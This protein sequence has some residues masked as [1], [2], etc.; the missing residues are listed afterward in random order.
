MHVNH[1]I[2]WLKELSHIIRYQNV[3]D[4]VISQKGDYIISN[5]ASEYI[6]DN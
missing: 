6:H 2:S 4:I 5:L 1:Q 3:M